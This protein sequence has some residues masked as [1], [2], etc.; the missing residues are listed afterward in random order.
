MYT[1]LYVVLHFYVVLQLLLAAVF[2]R[3]EHGSEG[4]R[5]VGALQQYLPLVTTEVRT[6]SGTVNPWSPGSSLLEGRTGHRYWKPGPRG[7]ARATPVAMPPGPAHSW[8]ANGAF[9]GSGGSGGS[10]QTG[11]AAPARL[12]A[13]MQ[14]VHVA[15]S[16]KVRRRDQLR[17][18]VRDTESAVLEN[19]GGAR[20]AMARTR[21]EQTREQVQTKHRARAMSLLRAGYDRSE[22]NDPLDRAAATIQRAV[23]TQLFAGH[24]STCAV[25]L[26]CKRLAERLLYGKGAPGVAAAC[27]PSGT[28]IDRVRLPHAALL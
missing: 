5:T 8:A 15:A 17:M 13:A 28:S 16:I 6:V 11:A 25:R 18:Q 1:V 23:R 19:P 10:E 2:P 7:G 22:A 24:R 3:T 21:T 9:G 14:R 12:L 4:S 20:R 27:A 26:H